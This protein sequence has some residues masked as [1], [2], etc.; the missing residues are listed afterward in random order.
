VVDTLRLTPAPPPAGWAPPDDLLNALAELL[1]AAPPAAA[2]PADAPAGPAP[3]AAT[4]RA[5]T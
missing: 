4:G 5:A 3:P 2:P 1:A